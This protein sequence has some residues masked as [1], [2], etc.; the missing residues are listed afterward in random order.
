[1]QNRPKPMTTS[2]L[3]KRLVPHLRMELTELAKT[4]TRL[5]DR[6][7]GSPNRWADNTP[8]PLCEYCKQP[9]QFAQLRGEADG[10]PVRLGT[11]R[12]LQLFACHNGGDCGFYEA[13]SRAHHVALRMK[14]LESGL[15]H[16]PGGNTSATVRDPLRFARE[17]SYVKGADDVEA[18]E[19]EEDEKRSEA[20]YSAGFVDKLYGVPVAGNKP[21]TMTCTKCKKP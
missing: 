9:L 19:D 3:S 11:A 7:G 2:K 20:A 13:R 10:G 12:W 1:M 14:P 8:W 16:R 21:D 17:I 15:V 6:L 4:D 18:L 5:C